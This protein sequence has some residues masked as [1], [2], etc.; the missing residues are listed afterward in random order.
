METAM[1]LSAASISDHYPDRERS[2][3]G[4]YAEV[5]GQ[6]VLA[7]E[8]GYHALFLA[9]HH[10]HE[11][12][13][14]PNPAVLLASLAQR[15]KQLR[16]GTSISVLPFRNVALAAE[17]YAML[18][19]LSN[20]RLELGVGSGYLKHEF[21]GFGIDAAEK[22]QRFEENLDL[23]ERLLGGERVTHAGRFA[24]LDG[25]RLNVLPVQKEVP[26]YVA[27]L[28]REGAYHIGHQG[29][30]MMCVPYAT[31]DSFEEIGELVREF[32]RGRSDAGLPPDLSVATSVLLHTHIATSDAEV[33]RNAA[34]AFDLYVATRLYAKRVVYD[35]IMR[36][37]LAL[38][39]S[40]ETVAAKMSRLAEMGVDHVMSLHNFGL[41][42]D[43]QVR[44]SMRAMIEEVM[45]RVRAGH[46]SSAAKSGAVAG[47]AV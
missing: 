39:G 29:R 45:P 9:E 47:A 25:I 28:R 24:T 13:A 27:T 37:G 18:D 40:V 44:R 11:Y 20:G 3:P 17:D 15:T 2:V 46:P 10:F 19:V 21:A 30:R 26:I 41:M 16:L 35:D 23:L 34:E 1:L 12:G 42:P 8:L 31:L 38:F 5:L 4:L 7:D 14:V 33:R 36:S 43:A 32:H 6:G 22:R